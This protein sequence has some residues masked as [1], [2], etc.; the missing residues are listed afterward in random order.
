MDKLHLQNY[1][2]PI[3]ASERI[4]RR[5]E[6]LLDQLEEAADRRD[7][8][9]VR[10]FAADI[11]AVD[12]DNADART[13]DI[14][15]GRML[16]RTRASED[17]SDDSIDECCES[18]VDPSSEGSSGLEDNLLSELSGQ[19]SREVGQVTPMQSSEEEQAAGNRTSSEN[20]SFDG[21]YERG[22]AFLG[23]DRFEEARSAFDQAMQLRPNEPDTL[24]LRAVAL[25][26]LEDP[27]LLDKALADCNQAI[28]IRPDH[29][30]YLWV[31]ARLFLA[32]SRYDESLADVDRARELAPGIFDPYTLDRFYSFAAIASMIMVADL[33]RESLEFLKRAITCEPKKYR[34][35]ASQE[36]D[37]DLLRDDPQYGPQFQELLATP[38]PP[39]PSEPIAETRT[40]ISTWEGLWFYLT[41]LGIGGMVILVAVL[42][43]WAINP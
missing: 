13:Y 28:D 30:N 35:L 36:H 38:R 8:E 34:D 42:A 27:V 43:A 6:R 29:Y 9:V 11:L 22:V 14:A 18:V 17:F 4:Q 16:S 10:Q 5:I 3:M 41:L 40:S 19:A 20:E 12:P 39:R 24:S 25:E 2:H 31:R 26:G 33:R 7:W 37:F 21:L 1:H 23:Q 32:L 15:A